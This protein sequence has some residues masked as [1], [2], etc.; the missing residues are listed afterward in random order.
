MRLFK[1]FAHLL[2]NVTTNRGQKTE[3]SELK[4][5]FLIQ[6]TTPT[7]MDNN[8]KLWLKQAFSQTL[9][10]V[11]AFYH[12]NRNDISSQPTISG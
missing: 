8:L 11:R 3:T 6:S 12:R 2:P 5:A 10:F 1:L 7:I 4:G 9:L